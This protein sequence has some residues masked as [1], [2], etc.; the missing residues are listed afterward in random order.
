MCLPCVMWLEK[1]ILGHKG[2]TAQRIS[3]EVRAQKRRVAIERLRA[4]NPQ[5][6]MIST[7][8]LSNEEE[9]QAGRAARCHKSA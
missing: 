4:T 7:L 3:R 1:H 9:P 6:P 5:Y 8:D 2:Y